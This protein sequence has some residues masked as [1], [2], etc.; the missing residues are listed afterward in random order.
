MFSPGDG[1][2]LVDSVVILVSRIGHTPT[3]QGP[4][5]MNTPE[6]IFAYAVI[7][8]ALLWASFKTDHHKQKPGN[9][10]QLPTVVPPEP[11]PMEPLTEDRMRQIMRE[12]MTRVLVAPPENEPNTREAAALAAKRL[13]AITHAYQLD[14]V[15]DSHVRAGAELFE[16]IATRGGHA[17]AAMRERL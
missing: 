15:H 10:T 14:P 6:S 16:L 8:G 13:R 1:L 17:F 11:L 5:T 2:P 7:V 9:V 12:E 3:T 4:R